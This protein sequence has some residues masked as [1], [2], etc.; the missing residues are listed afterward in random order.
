MFTDMARRLQTKIEEFAHRNGTTD[1]RKMCLGTASHALDI[2]VANLSY[3][4][5]HEA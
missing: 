1:Q 3:A 4:A 2:A 5:N